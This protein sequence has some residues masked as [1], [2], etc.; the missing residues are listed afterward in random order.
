MVVFIFKFLYFTIIFFDFPLW[1][2]FLW[3]RLS[4]YLNLNFVEFDPINNCWIKYL[5]VLINN[6]E[7][8]IFCFNVSLNQGISVIFYNLVFFWPL[9][10]HSTIEIY[11]LILWS[12]IKVKKYIVA[13]SNPIDWRAIQNIL[14]YFPTVDFF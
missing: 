7:T 5:L 1:R 3:V 10:V 12:R 11:N 8:L 6:S 9:I 14:R 2:I 13:F 4:V